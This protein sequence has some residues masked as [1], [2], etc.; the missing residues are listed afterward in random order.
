M[1][2]MD[3]FSAEKADVT[4]RCYLLP[5]AIE[6][7]LDEL[8]EEGKLQFSEEDDEDEDEDTPNEEDC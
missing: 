8:E 7:A 2:S 5:Q 6:A 3:D 4:I 1:T